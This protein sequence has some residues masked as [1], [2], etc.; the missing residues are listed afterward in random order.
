MR[1]ARSAPLGSHPPRSVTAIELPR[2]ERDRVY[3]LVT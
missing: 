1:L 2:D 3:E